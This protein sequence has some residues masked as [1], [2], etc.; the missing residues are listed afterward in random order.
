[1]EGLLLVAV[2]MRTWMLDLPQLDH[3]GTREALSS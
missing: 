1:M 3:L 2:N